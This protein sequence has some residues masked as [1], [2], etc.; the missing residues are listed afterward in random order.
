MQ[1]TAAGSGRELSRREALW[2]GAATAAGVVLADVVVPSIAHAEE[3]P[4]PGPPGPPPPPSYSPAFTRWIQPLAIPPVVDARRG[5]SWTMRMRSGSHQF[6]PERGGTVPT[7]GYTVDGVTRSVRDVYLGPTFEVMR[8]RE[9]V[10]RAVNQLGP[11]PLGHAM[12]PAMHGT[13][14]SDRLAPRTVVHLHGG[15]TESRYDG[16]PDDVF[17]PGQSKT[18]VY[19][20]DQ[21]ATTLWYHDHAIGIT[22]LNV[23]AGLSGMYLVRDRYDTGRGNRLGLPHGHHEVPLIIQD[24][25]FE[26]TEGRFSYRPG[27]LSLWA[28]G[29]AGDT[30]VVNGTAWPRLDVDRTVYRFRV[31][32]SSNTR[33]YRLHLSEPLPMYQIGTDG[34]L[35]GAPEPIEGILMGPGERADIL[36]DFSRM[37]EGQQVLLLNDASLPFPGGPQSLTEIMAFRAGRR[38]HPA[39]IPTRLRE[40]RRRGGALPAPL[41][42]LPSPASVH[43]VFANEVHNRV[44]PPIPTA[45]LLNN[46]GWHQMSMDP[47]LQEA[48]SVGTLAQWEFVNVSTEAHPMHVHLVQFRVVDRQ[49]IDAGA[50][51]DAVNTM[52]KADGII[53]P[54]SPG[55]PD[56]SASHVGPPY[57]RSDGTVVRPPLASGFA[58]RPARPTRGAE[59]GWRDTVL[60]NPGEVVRVLAPYGGSESMPISGLPYDKTFSGEYV[61]HCHMLEHE[62]HDMMHPYQVLPSV[63][64]G[65][66]DDG[67]HGRPDDG[68]HGRHGGGTH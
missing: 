53:P 23:F 17:M 42:V 63:S 60:V 34:G 36:I 14:E 20:N 65:L 44:G 66:P 50:Y 19:G 56:A 16:L 51:L 49:P 30:A 39:R 33:N 24:R 58:T 61:L 48:P 21:E 31:L 52:L 3:A 55:I 59:A 32:N 7:Y 64:H 26:G 11:H 54:E 68:S 57:V 15:H 2:L 38:R 4:P 27:P 18:Y 22:R 41:P 67:S 43:T 13:V 46:L 5:G 9:V 28:P 47:R 1:E 35:L 45:L 37:I 25:M 62:D 40:S 12:D 29:F 8:G 6:H 10:V